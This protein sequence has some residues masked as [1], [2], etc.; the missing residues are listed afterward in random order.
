MTGALGPESSERGVANRSGSQAARLLRV[1]CRSGLSLRARFALLMVAAV[2]GLGFANRLYTETRVLAE[3]ESELE[4]RALSLARLAADECVD[5]LLHADALRLKKL[6]DSIRNASPDFA[7]AFVLDPKDRVL[8]HS[9]DGELPDALRFLNRHRAATGYHVER[10]AIFGQTYRDFAL[11]LAAGELGV[12]RLGV[13]DERLLDRVAAIRRELLVLLFTVMLAAAGAAYVFTTYSLRPIKTIGAVLERFE[14]GRRREAI[15][16]NRKDE[17]GH[18][19][20]QVDAVTLRL[21]ETYRQ[22]SRTEKMAAVGVMAAGVAHE[23]N[24]P[25]TGIQNCLRRIQQNPGDAAQTTEYVAV[26]L[27]A[28]LHIESVVRG[29]LEYSRTSVH[30][31]AAVDL[32]TIVSRAVDLATLR[33]QK[34]KVELTRNE[35]PSP[36]MIVGDSAQLAQV[37]INVL[38]NAIDA[39]PGGGALQISVVAN[40]ATAILRIKDSGT[41][42]A[43]A[44]LPH[45]FDP[46]FTTKEAGKGTGLGLAVSHRIVLDHGGGIEIDSAPGSGTEVTVRLPLAARSTSRDASAT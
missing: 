24:N 27:Q 33:L 2:A 26:M 23:I 1:F 18:L 9:F 35:P 45:V 39:M 43:D 3:M 38:L 13:R 10:L 34:Q 7:Y 25:V 6:L 37:V 29:L 36:V 20:A 11:P 32:R 30:Q 14:P 5:V 22:M 17:L 21:H 12:L 42:I 46:F 44:D 16:L 41:G 15:A 40:K 28:T 31:K 4:W 19:A 8:G